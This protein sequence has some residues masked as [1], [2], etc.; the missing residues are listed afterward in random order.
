MAW[1]VW[2]V[3]LAVAAY[4]GLLCYRAFQF[5]P[6]QVEL[7]APRQSAVPEMPVAVKLSELV[8]IPTV[9][10]A[11]SEVF[12]AFQEKVHQLFPLVAQHCARVLVGEKGI[13]YRW[14]GQS[15]GDPRVFMAHYDV[16]PVQEEHWTRPPFS[17]DIADGA[18]WGRGTMDTKCTLTA[19]LEAVETLLQQGFVPQQDIY[20]CFSGDE[21]IAGPTAPKLLETLQGWGVVPGLVVDE[22]G[23]LMPGAFP[24]IK[25]LCALIGVAEKGLAELKVT[26]LA[27]PGHASAPPRHT[28]LGVLAKG[29]R[30]LERWPWPVK[31]TAP[32]LHMVDAL[33]RQTGFLHRLVFANLR[34]LK[35][36]I[37]LYTACKGGQLSAFLR[38][39]CAF[40]RSGASQAT[41]IL[42]E[43]AWASA[44]V[45]ILPGESV[46]SVKRRAIK[47]LGS[48]RLKV[49]VPL[50]H[51]PS[52]VSA[53]QGSCW[54]ALVAAIHLVWPEALVAPTLV[55][56]ATD[57]RHYAQVSEHVYRFGG[58]QM[59]PQERDAVHGHDERIRLS[60]LS[61]AVSFYLALM[62]QL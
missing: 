10:S 46:S 43:A 56:G 13:I 24:G 57:A 32:Y 60:S 3:L 20:F 35:P 41:S 14:P 21:E 26:A 49:E 54:D 45:R 30:R 33:G 11:E 36:F 44:N 38:T 37:S 4:V 2:V 50:G 6:Q 15:S 22:G 42:P 39:T 51:E 1:W 40:T 27:S 47:V 58:V 9:S 34:L 55:T 18:V 62:G 16:V 25:E 7:G 53:I 28:A 31:Y 17:G 5:K 8:Q 52:P 48:K 59:T 19:Q 12:S 23:T 29:I 61:K